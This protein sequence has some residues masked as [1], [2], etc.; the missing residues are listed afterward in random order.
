[1]TQLRTSPPSR[2]KIL[3]LPVDAISMVEATG[4]ILDWAVEAQGRM[5]CAADVHMVMRHADEQDFRAV[6]VHADMVTPD[7]MPLVWLLRRQGFPS[8]ERVCGPDLTLALC[9]AAAQRGLKVGFYGGKAKV[10]SML[11]QRLKDQFPLLEMTYAF[12]PPFRALDE[13]ED[14]AQVEAV[15]A[16]GVQL[17]FVGLGCPKQ[18]RWIAA[19]KSTIHAVMLGVGAAFDFHAGVIKRAP[20]LFQRLGLEWLFRVG[21]EPT[22]LAKRAMLHVP[23]FL[24][25]VLAR[26]YWSPKADASK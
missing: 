11:V 17:L 10:L 2:G 22:R 1:M 3:D 20:I 26:A 13:S 21:S 18:E 12:S 24:W 6:L 8:Q 23:R 4:L 25:R 7:G 14:L 9:E 15:N 19:H 16:A 5:V